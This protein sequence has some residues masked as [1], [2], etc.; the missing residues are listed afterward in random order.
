MGTV[1]NFLNMSYEPRTTNYIAKL[2]PIFIALYLLFSMISISAS[3]IF[4]FLSL[5][6]WLFLLATKKQKLLVPSFFWVLVVY[7]ILS[8]IS[9][10]LSVDP[11]LSLKD[12]RELLLFL[13]VPI[14]FAG[15]REA[16]EVK[17]A[18]LALLAS[19]CISTIY[20]IFHYVFKLAYWQREPG[21]MGQ[22]MTQ[23]GL[24]IL[25][26]SMALSILLFNCDKTRIVWGV[27]LPFAFVALILTQ[28]RS[29]WIGLVA[30]VIVILFLH[31]PKTLIIVPIAIG[32]FYLLSSQLIK[33]KALSIFSLKG[34]SNV[35]R[36]EFVKAGIKI[37]KD[38][39]LFGTGPDTV[40]IVF[41]DSK[42]GLSEN[43]KKNVHLHNN[44]VQI[45]A[46]RGIPT[47][48]T[49]LAFI[50]WIF[51]SQVKL[52]K[53]K[54][55]ALFPLTVAALAA[56]FALF[57]AGQFEYNFGDSEITAL[58]LYIVTIPFALEHRQRTRSKT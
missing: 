58:F 21:F 30:A 37:I 28:I 13:I 26:I 53:N 2:L 36:L 9:S 1:P 50:V 55:P 16:K 52:L 54:D 15:F 48:L 6:C 35:E 7:G 4:L 31:K 27:V 47:L 44:I 17:R 12:S 41:Q 8:L 40:D 49:W 10:F 45:G 32:I 24:L 38:Y 33:T 22:P 29:S 5:L 20:A 39:P 51:L 34:E 25:F 18:N 43:V 19:A 57:T 46:E 3:Q 23:A 11:K 42:Y 56:L 14:F